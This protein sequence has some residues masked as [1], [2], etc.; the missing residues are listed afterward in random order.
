[1]DKE[2]STLKKIWETACKVLNFIEMNYLIIF[3]CFIGLF[4]MV[5]VIM[6]AFDA[7]GS[8]W[9]EELA[10][11]MLVTTTLVGSSVAVKTKGHMAMTALIGALPAKFSNCLEILS[12]LVCGLAFLYIS[13]YSITWTVNLYHVKRMM[14]SVSIPIWPFWAIISFAFVTTGVR[15]LMQIKNNVVNIKNGVR[16]EADLKEM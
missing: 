13:Y 4:I 1:M 2:K 8:R 6:R 9:I 5:E 11:M 7:Q 16:P 15:F 3:T 14:D 12:N 10:R